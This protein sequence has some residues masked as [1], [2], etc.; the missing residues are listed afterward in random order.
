LASRANVAKSMKQI[1]KVSNSFQSD[2]ILRGVT[3][4]EEQILFMEA[5][6][7]AGSY[8]SNPL[9]SYEANSLNLVGEEEISREIEKLKSEKETI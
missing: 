7:Q 2:T 5:E 8:S 4:A 1:Q 9:S 6:V 3:K